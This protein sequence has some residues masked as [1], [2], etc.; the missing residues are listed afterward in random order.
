MP[1]GIARISQRRDEVKAK[2]SIGGS[3]QNLWLRDG[4]Q[5]LVNLIPTGEEDDA[6]LDDFFMHSFQMPGDDGSMRWNSSLCEKRTFE[7][8]SKACEH[9]DKDEGAQHQFGVW[10][11]VHDVFHKENRKDSGWEEIVSPRGG[12]KIY[13][14]TVNDFRVFARGFGSRDYLWNQVV[15]LYNE[16]PELASIVVRIKRTGSA[17]DD[18]TYSVAA[19]SKRTELSEEQ[20]E[21][22]KELPNI[23]DFFMEQ[24]T[25]QAQGGGESKE[26][27]K[28][29]Q[30]KEDDIASLFGSDSDDDDELF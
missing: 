26:T 16:E 23:R 10:C 19:T 9:C 11:L 30:S 7:D 21:K 6:R 14:E 25:T 29:A 20:M 13:K 15:D 5:A 27:S 4:D 24:K 1:G 12:T 18:T 2:Q 28:I 17:R 8:S 22:A 3:G